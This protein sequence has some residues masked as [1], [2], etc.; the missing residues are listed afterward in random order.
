[1]IDPFI[2]FLSCTYQSTVLAFWS[3]MPSLHIRSFMLSYR[4]QDY[5]E[6]IA[7]LRDGI[8]ETFT[9]IFQG[10]VI[11]SL[12][13]Q[14]KNAY[15]HGALNFINKLALDENRGEEVTKSAAGL[16]GDIIDTC[17]V[18][19]GANIKQTAVAEMQALQAVGQEAK[20]QP[21]Y[22]VLVK[23]CLTSDDPEMVSALSRIESRMANAPPSV[24]LL[25]CSVTPSNL[26][27]L[28]LTHL[29]CFSLP[30][31]SHL[32]DQDW[33]LDID[34]T[35]ECRCTSVEGVTKYLCAFMSFDGY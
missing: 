23:E 31:H 25:S 34:E 19:V 30:C 4:T 14:L 15:G 8:L 26:L 24:R 7:Q 22:S 3:L 32:P 5:L 2:S 13:P 18:A 27:L 1:M 35:L 10:Q 28:F 6:F 17:G 16:L 21:F 9:M 12:P 33:E 11:A 20:F 29:L